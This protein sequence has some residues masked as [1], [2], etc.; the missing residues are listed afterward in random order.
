LI[1]YVRDRNLF[2]RQV[3]LEKVPYFLITIIFAGITLS[4][5]DEMQNDE[6][7]I[8]FNPLHR[9]LF[10]MVSFAI[11][12]LNFLFPLKLS[13]FYT[14][15]PKDAIPFYYYLAVPFF[16]AY[17]YA[18]YRTW[19]NSNKL[20]FF[21]L[22]FFLSNLFLTFL[23]QALSI[24]DVMLA[25]RYIYIPLIGIGL[26][27]AYFVENLLKSKRINQPTLYKGI[28]L[29]GVLLCIGSFTRSQVWENSITVFSDAIEK[30][31]WSDRNNPY[32]ALVYTNRGVERRANN[33]LPGA[34]EDYNKA[35][36]ANPKYGTAYLNRGNAYFLSNQYNLATQD[37]EMA[38]QLMPNSARA[39]SSRGAL[40]ASQQN[41]E[42]ALADFG[43]AI[44]LD[45]RNRD[46]LRNRIKLYYFLNQSL[47]ALEEIPKY[48][49]IYPGDPE[50][51]N[52]QNA[53]VAK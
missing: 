26:L 49:S 9:I 15:P 10:S 48:L 8:Y 39:Y 12:F 19:K 50:V 21:A 45:P 11:Y 34:L 43:K 36:E 37:F 42:L 17:L 20:V 4:I 24:R 13:T 30:E 32:L 14:L 47:R 53:L 44:E 35:L 31:D 6:M 46:A 52:I 40:R 5:K 28:I 16:I 38:I 23:S 1:D 41:N 25:D 27:V 22:V 33:D 51:I 3:L 2:S 18:I 29:V 7:M